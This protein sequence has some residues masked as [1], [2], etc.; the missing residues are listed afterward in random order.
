[1]G[2]LTSSGPNCPSTPPLCVTHASSLL[3][4]WRVTAQGTGEAAGNQHNVPIYP[5]SFCIP[6]P[7][8]S[9]QSL[10]TGDPAPPHQAPH[11]RQRQENEPQDRV[12]YPAPAPHRPGGGSG[13]LLRGWL[14]HW[15]PRGMLPAA[16][17]SWAP[18]S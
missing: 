5:C 1:M 15:A 12:S 3:P 2:P 11:P 17:A 16:A 18:K 6:A 8:F 10:G 9:Q 14:G 13:T 4:E 7:K